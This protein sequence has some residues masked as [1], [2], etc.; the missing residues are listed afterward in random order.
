LASTWLTSWGTSWGTSWDGLFVPPVEP[1]ATGVVPAGR[2]KRPKPRKVLVEVDGR[3]YRVESVAE[4]EAILTKTVEK[5]QAQIKAKPAEKP[6]L[7]KIEIR[8]APPKEVEWKAL[9][10]KVEHDLDRIYAEWLANDDE[11]ALIALFS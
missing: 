1:P 5:V 10:K 7:P 4:A 2:S 9:P 3:V 11:E 6:R 8:E